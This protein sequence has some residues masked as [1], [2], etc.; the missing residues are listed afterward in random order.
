MADQETNEAPQESAGQAPSSSSDGYSKRQVGL[1]GVM[2]IVGGV[3]QL[4]NIYS[5]RDLDGDGDA[6]GV[7]V[8][9]IINAAISC[10]V[11]VITGLGFLWIE[12]TD[13]GDYMLVASGPCRW[14]MCGW[15][16][17]KVKYSEIRDYHVAKTCW[18]NVP[19]YSCCTGVRL[20]NQC[21]CCQC[22]FCGPTGSLEGGCC[23][24]KTVRL[25]VNERMF[26][27]EANDDDSD[28]C[29]ENCC[30]KNCF[31][32]KCADDCMGGACGEG[33]CFAMCF[34]PCG[35]NCCAMN[36]MYISTND[37]SGLINLLNQKTGKEV[38]L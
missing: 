7:T 32:Q 22:S 35:V 23:G 38:T 24:Q 20:M 36:T 5:N 28:C 21:S 29:L 18:Y 2:L 30:L 9:S 1:I 19:E 11:Y 15:G 17:E 8:A 27:H 31:G 13:K 6:D 26:G 34:N 12:V 25:T 33:C 37:P 10:I 3:A 14:A 16:K 4:G